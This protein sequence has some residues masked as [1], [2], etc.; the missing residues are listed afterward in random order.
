M[1][2]LIRPWS[3]STTV[4]NPE[5]MRGFLRVF[6]GM[7]GADWNRASQT[8]FQIRLIQARLYGAF[9]AQ[10][11]SNLPQEDIDLLE[12]TAE[13]S[14]DDAASIFARK[15]YTDAPMRG[16]NSFKALQK[17]GFVNIIDGKVRITNSGTAFIAEND[18]YGEIF[19]RALLKWQLPNPLDRAG[20]PASHGYCIKPFVGVLHL[21]CTV[22]RLCRENGM[23]EKGLSRG[24]FE[25]FAI[26]L[27]DHREIGAMAEEIVRLR[28]AVAR[29][30]ATTRNDYFNDNARR[31]RSRFDLKH[32]GDYADNAIRYFRMTKY[33]HLRGWGDHIDIERSRIHEIESLLASDN[34]AANVSADAY[35]AYLADINQPELPGESKSELTQTIHLL[36]QFAVEQGEEAVSTDNRNADELKSIRDELRK[37]QRIR[38]GQTERSNLRNSD[39]VRQCAEELRALRKRKTKKP[40]VA[41]EWLTA[42]GLW[43][44][45]D[46]VKI[47]PNCP[48]GD[49]GLPTHNAPAGKADIECFYNDFASICEVTLLQDSKQ[50]IH[51]A[52]PV[53]R[54]LHAFQTKHVDMDSYCIFIAPKLHNDTI[55][56]F[57]VSA[58]YGY[59][60]G[61]PQKFVPLTLAEFCGILDFCAA[62]LDD[63]NPITRAQLKSLFDD[64]A[65][66]IVAPQ[67]SE[68]WREQVSQIIGQ[69]T[70]A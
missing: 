61:G 66:S 63:N 26:T 27:I 2:Q 42:R 18:D 9:N 58:K 5:R 53:M 24:E 41:L 6:A 59:E 55:N 10:F 25:L 45:N 22:N 64:V 51:E 70:Q 11:Y 65:Q 30:R 19:L 23:K 17:F 54:H 49:D 38:V 69:W 67:A 62:R 57:R 44:L 68:G 48:L 16:R 21:I 46:A 52:Q 1:S 31:L 4:R 13:I 20:F 3:I 7:E 40:A 56:A 12:S 28:K 14:H 50:W 36:N 34:A 15:G 39:A 37:A 33:I 32:V 29:T 47:A 35:A 60:G 43:A 8:D